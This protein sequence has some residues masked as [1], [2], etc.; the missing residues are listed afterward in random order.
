MSRSQ[1]SVTSWLD[2]HPDNPREY[3]SITEPLAARGHK[4]SR[5]RKNQASK[6]YKL[7]EMSHNTGDQRSHPDGARKLDIELASGNRNTSEPSKRLTRST[8]P[9]V[10]AE[11]PLTPTALH[12]LPLALLDED[13]TPKANSA[14]IYSQRPVLVPR[15]LSPTRPTSQATS[16]SRDSNS[17]TTRSR[18][19]IKRLGDFKLADVRVKMIAIGTPR[20]SIPSGVKD[21]YRDL[22]SISKGRGVIPMAV[23]DTALAELEDLVDD[24]NFGPSNGQDVEQ[25]AT[26]SSLDHHGLWERVHE[27]LDAA[28]E[29]KNKELAEASWNSEVHS[30]IL[31]LA[32]RGWWQSKDI[33]YCDITTAKIHDATLLPTA[34]TGAKMQSKMV[35]Y[36][37]VLDEPP[38]LCR[39]IISTLIAENKPSINHTTME[40]L[41]FSP[42]AVSIETKR[43]AVDEDTACVQL[44]VW[45]TAHFARL[46]Q[47]TNGNGSTQLP[48][49]PLVIV[50][51][52]EWK[53]MFAEVKA[54]TEKEDEQTVIHNYLRLGDTNSVLGTYQIVEAIRR[55]ARWVEEDYKPWF[56][57][58]VLAISH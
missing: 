48:V 22:I 25:L 3:N 55:L 44:A 36:A 42:I 54:R 29:C 26:R 41:R 57:R 46:R 49:L 14:G 6:R 51:G 31:R 10:P 24:S 35:D 12:S 32:L 17:R 19:P 2:A 37:L 58:E 30:S 43:G 28:L 18:S 15:P 27:I 45:V 34:A 13:A 52:F 33:W 56:K 11:P 39:G 38:D 8:A 5:A 4:R 9:K 7:R 1:G 23:K 50:Q 53:L 40:A 47:L 21:L 20:Y 16:S